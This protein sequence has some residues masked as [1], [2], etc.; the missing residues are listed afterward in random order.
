MTEEVRD[1]E[2]EVAPKLQKESFNKMRVVRCWEKIKGE[3][4]QQRDTYISLQIK[5]R[6]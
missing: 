1:R 2:S 3:Q 6:I 4:K 5:G